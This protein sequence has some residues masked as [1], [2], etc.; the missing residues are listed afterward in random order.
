MG[1]IDKEREILLQFK[2]ELKDPLG[3][4]SPWELGHWCHVS[5]LELRRQYYCSDFEENEAADYYN[6]SCLSGTLCP[7]LL[8]LTHVN[9]S[10]LINK[11]FHG[12]PILEFIG[13]LRNLRYLNLSF[14]FFTGMVPNNLGNLSNLQHLDLGTYSN[15]FYSNQ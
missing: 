12:V 3:W 7:Y 14:V 10:D 9:Y 5:R 15:A 13:S 6:I 4:L 2:E 11:N 1:C 8:N